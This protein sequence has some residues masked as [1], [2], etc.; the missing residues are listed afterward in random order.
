M[1]QAL[2]LGLLGNNVNTSGQV[3]LTAGVSGT[4]PVANGGTGATTIAANNVI[5]GNGTSAVQVVAPSTSG[6][7][8][9][10]NG[11]TWTSAAPPAVAPTKT[12]VQ[13]AM[14]QSGV[15]EVGTFSTMRPNTNAS[16]PTGGTIAGSS[17]NYSGVG[18][19]GIALGP[20]ATGTWRNMS[21]PSPITGCCFTTPVIA[22]YL[23]I[24]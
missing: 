22:V 14:A 5:L 2:N 15:G 3:S 21:G 1:T 19:P 10:S 13:N 11:S 20:T 6:N 9:T 8:L 4:L 23:R 12:Q 18:N 24:S 7:V 16:I 17:L